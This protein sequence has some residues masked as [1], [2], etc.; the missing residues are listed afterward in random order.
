MGRQPR[1]REVFAVQ[2]GNDIIAPLCGVF[3]CLRNGLEGHYRRRRHR[4]VDDGPDAARPRYRLRA[5]R[6][7]R[8]RPRAR[9]RHQHPAAC[10]QGAAAARAVGAARRGRH[11]HLRA[12]LHQPVRPGDLARA[13]RPRRRL[14]RAAVL[15]PSR[16]AAGRDPPGG[17]LAARREPHP[18]RPSARRLHPGRGR[19]HR[20]FLRPPWRAPRTRCAATC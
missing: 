6:A 9:R 4:W 19:R 10:H 2:A 5:V 15:D 16:P 7:G 12:D 17:A 1:G 18:H 20:L 13:A 3:A 8:R 14:R 11:P